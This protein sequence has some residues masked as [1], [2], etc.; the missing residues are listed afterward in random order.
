MFMLFK[1]IST[2]KSEMIVTSDDH[3]EIFQL[4]IF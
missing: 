2:A 3:H 1:K 4:S